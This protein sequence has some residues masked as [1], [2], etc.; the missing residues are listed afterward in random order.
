MTK[1]EADRLV[2][3]LMDETRGGIVASDWDK[4]INA[5]IRIVL[6]AVE[7]PKKRKAAWKRG[8]R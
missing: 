2:V 3:R 1:A 6:D 8:K 7:A 4:A 5:A